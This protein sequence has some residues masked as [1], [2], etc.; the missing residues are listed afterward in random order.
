MSEKMPIQPSPD[1][2]SEP[3]AK[4]NPKDW[5]QTYKMG[6]DKSEHAIVGAVI[7]VGAFFLGETV[8]E[9]IGLS[10]KGALIYAILFAVTAVLGIMFGKE[11]W[12]SLGHGCADIWD[13]ICGILPFLC[14]ILPIIIAYAYI[15]L[16]KAEKGGKE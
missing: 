7:G 13:M 16:K 3:K 12:D 6:V 11:V 1:Q 2:P 15:T 14:V 9:G 5:N 10:K 8:L 4:L